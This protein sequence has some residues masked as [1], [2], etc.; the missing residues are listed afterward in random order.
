MPLGPHCPEWVALDLRLSHLVVRRKAYF[1]AVIDTGG[2]VW[3]MSPDY[4]I[5]VQ[6]AAADRFYK[7]EIKPRERNLCR[8]GPIW[9]EHSQGPDFYVAQSFASIYFLV[10]WFHSPRSF[11]S[12]HH[13]LDH[14]L[15]IIEKL[16][17]A[18]PPPDGPQSSANAMALP[19]RS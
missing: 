3:C 12:I 9:L 4:D 2:C 10:I 7:S 14:E 5:R 1:A 17:L 18:L 6:Y 13:A 11:G 19:R 16:T 15:P 8:T